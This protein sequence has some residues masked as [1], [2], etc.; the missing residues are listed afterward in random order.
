MASWIWKTSMYTVLS[1]LLSSMYI[2]LLS[3]S[4]TEIKDKIKIRKWQQHRR[5]SCEIK[6]NSSFFFLFENYSFRLTASVKTS[7]QVPHWVGF[8]N[9]DHWSADCESAGHESQVTICESHVLCEL[10]KIEVQDV[11]YSKSF[12]LGSL[13]VIIQIMQCKVCHLLYKRLVSLTSYILTEDNSPFTR[14]PTDGCSRS[15]LHPCRPSFTG[16]LVVD[17][18]ANKGLKQRYRWLIQLSN[19]NLE[20]GKH[21][22]YQRHCPFR[23]WNSPLLW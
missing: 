20:S 23:L 9:N 12:G 5:N 11:A 22:L 18:W 16:Q 13:G 15:L 6:S 7:S 21:L 4:Y 19:H 17:R 1:I 3:I 10:R 14:L 8:L 2:Y